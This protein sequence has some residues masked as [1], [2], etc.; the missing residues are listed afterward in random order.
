MKLLPIVTVIFGAWLGWSRPAKPR[1]TPKADESP[2]KQAVLAESAPLLSSQQELVA[3]FHATAP[4]RSHAESRLALR[5]ANVTAELAGQWLEALSDKNTA[6]A[7]AALAA[8]WAERTPSAAQGWVET[9]DGHAAS[10]VLQERT[11]AVQEQRT[12][13]FLVAWNIVRSSPRGCRA[14]FGV[15][16]NARPSST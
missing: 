8:W 16:G 3:I 2:S 5:Q 6:A 11:A 15:G 14:C 4:Q 13:R 7:Q 9:H 12:Y 1:F 10:K